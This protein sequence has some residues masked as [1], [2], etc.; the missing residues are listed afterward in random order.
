LSLD[1]EGS[2]DIS[3]NDAARAREEAIQDTIENAILK[4]TAK[5]MSIPVGDN[6]FQP[7]KIK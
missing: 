4:A 6:R 2:A 1:V 7:A 5:L 3:Q